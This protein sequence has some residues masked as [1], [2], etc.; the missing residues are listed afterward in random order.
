MFKYPDGATPIAP[1]ELMDLIPIHITT[2]EELNAWE[3]K[4]IRVAQDWAAKQDNILSGS[5]IQLFHKNM[6]DQTWRWAGKYRTTE[7]NLGIRWYLIA[8]AVE[9]LCF[10]VQY[11]LEHA[12]FSPDEIAIRFHH[13][14][15]WIHPFPNGNGRHARLMADLL[16]IQMGYPCFNWGFDKDLHNPTP[17]RKQYIA[18]LQCADGGDFSKLLLFARL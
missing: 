6:F 14:L 13:Q 1:E 17:V 10:N 16:L 12:V 8:E 15:V 18:A 3:E 2:Q 11:Q 4:N 9:K 7:K 5:F